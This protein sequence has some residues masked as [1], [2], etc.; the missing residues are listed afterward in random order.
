MY[1]ARFATPPAAGDYWAGS[2]RWLALLPGSVLREI[3]S[4]SPVHRLV[5][6]HLPREGR[7]LDA[8]CGFGVLSLLNP[9]STCR[10]AGIDCSPDLIT[11]A[12]RHCPDSLFCA[13]LLNSLPYRSECFDAYFAVSSWELNHEGLPAEEAYRVL[14]K[15]GRLLVACPRL[16]FRL[17]RRSSEKIE[18]TMGRFILDPIP[19]PLP[20]NS[21]AWHTDAYGYYYSASE[22]KRA[23]SRAGFRDIDVV[24]SDLGG[25]LMY[26][27]FPGR[28]LR[29]RLKKLMD[30]VALKPSER[31]KSWT[32][33]LLGQLLAE[34]EPVSAFRFLRRTFGRFWSFWN[35]V[36]AVK[37]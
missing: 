31:S 7:A 9:H 5:A 16:P 24:H 29:S 14:R 28:R 11:T 19:A 23:I 25:G 36:L 8:G 37:G 34:E 6:S 12:A 20:S 10:I 33:R 32:D 30:P 17:L 15:G 22:L 27:T 3:F 18:T 4:R 26:S 13:G 2:Y 21:R 1:L 35:V